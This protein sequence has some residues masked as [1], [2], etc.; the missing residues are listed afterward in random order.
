MYAILQSPVSNVL[1]SVCIF[2]FLYLQQLIISLNVKY[3]LCRMYAVRRTQ[4]EFHANKDVTDAAVIQQQI[5]EAESNLQMMQRQV[6][7]Y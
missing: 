6:R 4:D 7:A 3:V 5:Q 2:V 1:S